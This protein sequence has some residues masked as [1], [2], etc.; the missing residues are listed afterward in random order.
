[1]GEKISQ[2]DINQRKIA[3]G[4]KYDVFFNEKQIRFA[5]SQL[6]RLLTH[7]DLYGEEGGKKLLSIVQRFSIFKTSYDIEYLDGTTLE[8]R[9]LSVIKG[10]YVCSSG[11]D[12]YEIFRHRKRKYS[13]FRNGLQVAWWDQ[14]AVTWFE[15]DNYKIRANDDCDIDLLIS[16]CLIIDDS[17]SNK[18]DKQSFTYNFGYIG[19][20][21]KKFDPGWSPEIG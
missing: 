2:I 10:H 13:I 21:A 9:T 11:N 6:M 18:S 17:R 5:R 14:E 3:F 7:I 8:F 4:Y 16:F 1:L 12:T 20:E 15:G 19:P